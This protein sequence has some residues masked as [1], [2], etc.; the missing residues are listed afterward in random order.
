MEQQRRAPAAPA[1]SKGER[2]QRLPAAFFVGGAIVASGAAIYVLWRR[3]RAMDPVPH[4]SM[5]TRSSDAHGGGGCA[6][7]RRGSRQAEGHSH[8]V[9]IA[10]PPPP[11]M[12]RLLTIETVD[13]GVVSDT[14]ATSCS[15]GGNGAT[16][17]WDGRV[18]SET[19]DTDWQDS[20][21]SDGSERVRVPGASQTKQAS[22][23]SHQATWVAKAAG[24]ALRAAPPVDRLALLAGCNRWSW[25]V[26]EPLPSFRRVKASLRHALVRAS[27]TVIASVDADIDAAAFDERF[28][29]RG[30]RPVVLR[31]ATKDWPARWRWTL[32]ELYAAW[33][34]MLFEVDH[35]H[36]SDA[37]FVRLR[38]W[39][40]YARSSDAV[41]KG[42]EHGLCE[43]CG[44]SQ[45]LSV[46]CLT[47]YDA[48]NR[49]F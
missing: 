31:G 7:P 42:F 4:E 32:P 41:P 10:P 26:Q 3:A 13:S 17:R 29:A 46:E 6:V 36:L 24:L 35:D 12:K 33:R 49:H 48:A 47:Q 21:G 14:E 25:L 2:W 39:I 16:E 40:A 8:A 18:D 15:S 11:Q 27:S 30:G 5:V 37:I 28:V 20:S 19:D 22:R 1:A 9:S 44:A 38:Y 23:S 34:D 43:C 45:L